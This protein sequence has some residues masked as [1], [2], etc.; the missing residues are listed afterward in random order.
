LDFM[1]PAVPPFFGVL[2]S[3]RAD[4]V[5]V[6]I[7]ETPLEMFSCLDG[8]RMVTI[9]PKGTLSTFP[10]IVLLARPPGDQLDQIGNLVLSSPI[11]DDEVDM[12]RSN[13]VVQDLDRKPFTGLI[14]PMLV[15]LTGSSEFEQEFPFVAAVSN[16]PDAAGQIKS[17]RS[18]HDNSPSNMYA[19][20]TKI[21]KPFFA[22]KNQDIRPFLGM[23]LAILS[24]FFIAYLGPTP[25]R[26]TR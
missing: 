13:R 17:I 26:P 19:A 12:V 11:P 5:E 21:Y 18:W 10:G 2:D 22:P 7:G 14:Q 25:T 3:P 15:A 9:F 23:K 20:D 8:G 24:V 6:D 4:H 1:V 16:M